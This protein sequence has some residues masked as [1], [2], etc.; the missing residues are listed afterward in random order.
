MR[1]WRSREIAHWLTDCLREEGRRERVGGREGEKRERDMIRGRE[2]DRKETDKQMQQGGERELE[3][4][5]DRLK[6][7]GYTE[8]RMTRRMS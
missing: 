4:K 6:R 5:K 8:I 1:A 2:K 7:E 3:K